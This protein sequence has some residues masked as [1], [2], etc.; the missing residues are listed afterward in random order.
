MSLSTPEGRRNVTLGRFRI[1]SHIATGGMGAVYRAYDPEADREVAL[2]VLMPDLV[3]GKPHLVERFRREA[4][5]GARLRHENLVSLYEFGEAAGTCFLVM[6]LVEGINLHDYIARSGPLD[7]EDA[8]RLLLQVVRALDYIHH[9]GI[10]HRDIKP[11]NVLLAH[12]EGRTV[13]KL[14]DLGLARQT[15]EEEFRLTREGH[16]VGTVDYM[17]P[18]QARNSDLADIRSDLYSLGCTFFH[19]LTGRPP[20]STGSLPERIFKHAET[21]PPDPRTLNPAVPADLAVV[22]RRMLAKKPA[23]RY[24]T[25]A[26]LLEVLTHGPRAAEEPATSPESLDTL[27][28]SEPLPPTDTSVPAASAE[29]PPRPCPA[30]DL[31]S[32][33][34]DIIA[35]QLAYAKGQI[36]RGQY[37]MGLHL[38]LTC[39]KMDPG[40]LECHQALRQAVR[41]A[42]RRPEGLLKLLRGLLGWARLKLARRAGNAAQVLAL[43]AEVLARQPDDEQ[44][45]LDMAAAADSLDRHELALWLLLEAWRDHQTSAPVNRALGQYFEKRRDYDQAATYWQRVAEADPLDREARNKLRDLAALQALLRTRKVDKK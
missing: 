24:Q 16:T 41:E 21:E 3:A 4:Q 14:S 15:R 27:R 33:A 19:M 5:H 2:K 31:P 22:V 23:D 34:A 32:P 13:A 39:C 1:L 9:Q 40:N 37:D 11:A 17:A 26:D 18:E 42:P 6:E 38:L 7:P 43:G 36:G 8:R 10:V 28:P 29:A 35:G 25:P 44:T 20:F 45:Q 12:K 30:G